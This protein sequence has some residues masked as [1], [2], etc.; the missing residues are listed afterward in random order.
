MQEQAQVS[1][2]A[3]G[4]GWRKKAGRESDVEAVREAAASSGDGVPACDRSPGEGTGVRAAIKRRGTRG[5][6]GRDDC[7]ATLAGVAVVAATAAAAAAAAARR[8]D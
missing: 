7:T 8:P 3:C 1:T 5:E 4:L 2:L 6:R